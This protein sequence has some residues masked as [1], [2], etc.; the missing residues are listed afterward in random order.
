MGYC[1]SY[2]PELKRKYPPYNR[3]KR[4]R[5]GWLGVLVAITLLFVFLS[6]NSNELKKWILPGNPEVTETALTCL[7]Q[8]VR[9]GVAVKEAITDFCLEIIN[10][11]EFEQ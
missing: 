4:K 1:I 5:N 11:G 2:N 10:N 8:D 7:V 3:V 6:G 9:D